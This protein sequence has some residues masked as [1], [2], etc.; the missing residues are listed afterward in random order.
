[1]IGTAAAILRKD[2]TVELRTRESVPAMVL[3]SVTVFV[4][5]HFGLDRDTLE[6]DLATGVIWVTLL[7]AALLGVNR[8]Y[9]A[10]RDQGGF[11]G[12]R[13]APIDLT[14]LWL[15]K[16]AALFLYLVVLEVVALPA[17]DLLLLGPGLGGALPE[18]L[19]ILL[20]ANLGLAAV[21]ALISALAIETRARDLIVPLLLL[22][23]LVPVIIAAAQATE[24]L[25]AAGQ[26]P[27]DLAQWL[28]FLALY[29][30]VF[31]LV[32][33]AVFDFLLDE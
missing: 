31:V 5:F 10:E 13:L 26:S 18:L 12:M 17:F 32:S 6:G 14:A 21:G 11:T 16:A 29:D 1:V 19:P 7:L 9:V 8:L 33:V 20:L 30:V 25:L 15:A 2:L 3:F 24:P 23:L 27:D 4:L 28:G 22:P